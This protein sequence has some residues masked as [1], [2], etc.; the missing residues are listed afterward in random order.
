MIFV[1]FV[2]VSLIVFFTFFEMEKR[3]IEIFAFEES[4]EY[5]HILDGDVK[6]TA[7]LDDISKYAEKYSYY[8]FDSQ[9]NLVGSNKFDE[10]KH[11]LFLKNAENLENK[12]LKINFLERKGKIMPY[13]MVSIR[14]D[15]KSNNKYLG[16]ILAGHEISHEF[17]D[18]LRLVFILLF[19]MLIYIFAIYRMTVKLVQKAIKPIQESLEAQKNFTANASHD[20][21]TPLSIILMSLECIKRDKENIFSDFSA[22]TIAD[23]EKAAK[24]MKN[25]TESLNILV[26]SDNDQKT[27]C[28][29]A[30]D[31]CKITKEIISAYSK[32]ADKKSIELM[33]SSELKQAIA[34][35]KKDDLEIVVANLLDNACK[36]SEKNSKVSIDLKKINNKF[37][38]SVIDDG[39][40]I[41]E[42]DIPFIFDR[43][44]RVEKSRTTEGSGLGLAIVKELSE[45]NN[46]ELKVESKLGK[47]SV[48][49]VLIPEFKNV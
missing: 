39:A 7:S 24:S 5:L 46:L 37:L 1:C 22:E 38:L 26:K 30:V 36:Y 15:I 23:M 44:Y 13:L 12:Q 31:V 2:V 41:P 47:G 10:P 3:N 16:Y 42:A 29:A 11:S 6:V 43:F 45:K 20:L 8:V 49:T 17:R 35:I 14:Q 25:L 40:G 28:K 9:E 48:F 21:K 19:V 32:I 18:L 33:Y 27:D 4:E 34:W